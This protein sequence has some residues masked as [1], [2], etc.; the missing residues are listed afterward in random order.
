[1]CAPADSIRRTAARRPATTTTTTTTRSMRSTHC[2]QFH[3]GV[4]HVT[5][6]IRAVMVALE[7]RGRREEHS[8]SPVAEAQ[9]SAAAFT[10]R[11]RLDASDVPSVCHCWISC[12]I[13]S[14]EANI[15]AECR[16]NLAVTTP[17]D[18]AADQQQ[19][20]RLQRSL[21]QLEWPWWSGSDRRVAER[22]TGPVRCAQSTTNEFDW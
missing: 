13:V 21:G 1:M 5:L 2:A 12:S 19:Q 22:S 18:T 6:S 14:I 3:A 10:C 16:C 15:W 11:V 7:Q 9:R 8:G 17:A 4:T 20:R